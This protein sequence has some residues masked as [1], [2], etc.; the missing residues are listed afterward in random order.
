MRLY[1]VYNSMLRRCR[2]N[3]VFNSHSPDSKVHGANIRPIRVRQDPGG[4]HVGP[5][6]FVIWVCIPVI[7]LLLSLPFIFLRQQYFTK[8]ASDDFE[9][10][11]FTHWGRV[12]HICVSKLTVISSDNGLW[13]GRRQAIIWTNAW[14]LLF[15]LPRTCRLGNGDHFVSASIC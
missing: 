6:N 1:Y 9:K 2:L 10:M 11:S 5:V 12:T 15:G 7:V 3:T 8:L 14:K 13:P 4:T